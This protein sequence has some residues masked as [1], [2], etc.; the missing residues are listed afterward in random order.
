M[1]I[2]NE[3]YANTDNKQYKMK[4]EKRE[5]KKYRLK[6]QELRNNENINI[7]PNF[8]CK[9]TCYEEMRH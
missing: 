8:I 3:D 4:N 5:T 7:M 2:T 6:N 1:K 9:G